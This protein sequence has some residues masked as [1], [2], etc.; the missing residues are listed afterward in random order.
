[1]FR[2][3]LWAIAAAVRPKALL[4]ADNLCLRQQL[5]VLDRRKPRPRLEDADRR[6]WVLVRC[7]DTQKK[8]GNNMK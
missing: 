6:F 8:E 3:L 7:R 2:C 4:I 5:L 1:M